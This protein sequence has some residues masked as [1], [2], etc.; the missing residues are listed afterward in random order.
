MIPDDKKEEV[1]QAA[2]IIDVVSDHV[3]LRRS[4]SNFTGLCP[5]H[6][7]KTPSFNVSPSLGIYKCFGCGEAGDVFSFVMK[8]DGVG[9]E[10]AVR[11]LAERYNVTL[12]E[13]SEEQYD[14]QQ[15]F[16]DGIYHALRFAGGF[17]HQTLAET[18]EA[19]PARE[20]LKKR[21]YPWKTVRKYGLGYAPDRFDGLLRAAE[22]AGINIQY[23]HGAG[24]VK[25][26]EDGSGHY[27]TFRGRLMFPILNPSGKV[28]GFGG[29]TLSTDK[30]IPKYIN[31]PQTPVYNKS[32]VLYGIHVARNEIRKA[33]EVILVEGYTDV[34][35]MQQAGI[36][37][38]V[39]TSGTSLTSGQ[40]RVMKRYGD[41]LLMI[42]DADTA[43]VNAAVR[44]ISVALQEG[45]GV[46]VLTLPEGEDPDSYVREYGEEGFREIKKKETVDFLRFLV[47]L[48][49]KEDRWDD[50]VE[51]RKCISEILEAIAVVPDELSRDT[52]IQELSSISRI[53]DRALHKEIE[54]LR[55]R[56]ERSRRR[57]EQQA[58]HRAGREQLGHRTS[59][60]QFTSAGP[61]D[62]GRTYPGQTDPRQKKSDRTGSHVQA[63]KTE[64]PGSAGSHAQSG[65][66]GSHAKAGSAGSTGASGRST[67]TRMTAHKEANGS[68]GSS[69][70]P[71]SI[72]ER[73]STGNAGAG[74][75]G[76]QPLST[77]KM[78]GQR[79]PGYEKELIRLMLS[80]GEKLIVFIG[81][82]CSEEDFEDPDLRACY[83][84]IMKRYQQGE[85]VSV[86]A[87]SR[88]EHPFPELV[89]EVVLQR[90]WV[91]ELGMR[92]RGVSMHRD[93]DPVQT[94]RSALKSLKIKYLE[95][96]REQLLDRYADAPIAEKSEIL[97]WV[98]KATAELDRHRQEKVE[99][100]FP[101]P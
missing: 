77:L 100:L 61:S 28:I 12:P 96:L 39:S 48:A 57:F 9:F 41:V 88:R 52:Y 23:L 58:A 60:G 24:L 7:E 4:G 22:G 73:E 78:K 70:Q 38:V 92:K 68:S 76:D 19:G 56:M 80:F 54:A 90:H 6:N 18:D 59:S 5:F 94:A 20:Y 47:S 71:E 51:R 34:I 79:R 89:G 25:E 93:A 83:T 14:P 1:R 66:T 13:K 82:H 11:T 101:D 91:S 3:K 21:G 53:G 87:Y 55:G 17:F 97:G 26:R 16:K 30:K 32:E 98:K 75:L 8:M 35:S 43:G 45:M 44:G 15:F 67:T 74:G 85:P 50:P 95:R 29:R 2:D 63:G 81:S 33:G 64:A 31:S 49:R 10:E 40:V 42:F 27:D 86:E 69:S 37:N 62:S 65:T 99:S 46:R 36:G 72:D 84:D